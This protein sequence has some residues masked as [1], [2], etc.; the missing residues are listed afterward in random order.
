MAAELRDGGLNAVALSREEA[1]RA[2]AAQR[3]PA[4]VIVMGARDP[5]LRD[6]SAR[7]ASH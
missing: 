2:I 7:L 4:C 3:R 5:S 1:T 6:W